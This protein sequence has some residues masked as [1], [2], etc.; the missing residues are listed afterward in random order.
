MHS[1]A[2]YVTLIKIQNMEVKFSCENN[3][4]PKPIIV[5]LKNGRPFEKRS[6]GKVTRLTNIR[7]IWLF[8]VQFLVKLIVFYML[9]LNMY[10]KFPY[11]VRFSCCNAGSGIGLHFDIAAKGNTKGNWKY[12]PLD[13]AVTVLFFANQC[14]AMFF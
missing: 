7:E 12:F 4:V 9:N 8:S 14:P 6:M 1:N 13:F 11:H 2:S 10:L 5:W 3:L